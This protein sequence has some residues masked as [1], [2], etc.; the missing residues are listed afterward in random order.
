[1]PRSTTINKTD[2]HLPKC[3]RPARSTGKNTDHFGVGSCWL[4]GGDTLEFNGRWS[5]KRR[6]ALKER[7]ASLKAKES[8]YLD[9]EKVDSRKTPMVSPLSLCAFAMTLTCLAALVAWLRRIGP[10]SA[11]AEGSVSLSGASLL[12][13]ILL[14]I[15]MRKTI[16]IT[17]LRSGIPSRAVI[18]LES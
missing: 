16:I 17:R 13:G 18:L 12:L 1:M 7:M 10:R 11:L 2:A 4:H 5:V 3:G 15:D 9:L 14:Q 8:D 6:E